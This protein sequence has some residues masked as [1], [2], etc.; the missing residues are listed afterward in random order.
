MLEIVK[1]GLETSIQDFPGR[2]GYWNQGF[3]AVRPDGHVVVP[4][5]QSRG[6]QRRGGAGAGGPVHGA[7]DQVPARRRDRHD[8]RQHA[9]DPRRAADPDVGERGGGRRAD[10][11]DGAGDRRRARLSRGGWRHRRAGVAGLGVHLPQGRGRR[12]RRP[13]GAGRAGAPGEGGRRHAGAGASPIARGR[14]SQAARPGRSRQCGAPTTTGS[15]T[16]ATSASSRRRGCWR[17]GA[18]ARAIA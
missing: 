6:R 1:P 2:V 8:R 10:A 5:R 12:A 14:P 4:P 17:P 16:R 13:R 11:L 7:D 15:T 3:P 9:P 18:T